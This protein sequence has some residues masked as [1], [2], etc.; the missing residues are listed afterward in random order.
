M[1]G[2]HYETLKQRGTDVFKGFDNIGNILFVNAAR[3]QK[4]EGED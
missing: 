2:L 4:I 1:I 3:E